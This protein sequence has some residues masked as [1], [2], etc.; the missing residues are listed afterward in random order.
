M[1]V[2]RIR[3]L[4]AWLAPCLLVSL[5]PSPGAGQAQA[6]TG[7]LR[8]LIEPALARWDYPPAR[9]AWLARLADPAAPQRSLTLALR[10]LGAVREERAAD[11]IRTLALS[12]RLAGPVR[13]EAA[14]AL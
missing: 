5:S 10:G 12:D 13:Q 7:D 3:V 14:R 4:I 6:G 1:C 9:D 2:L 8:D 11:R